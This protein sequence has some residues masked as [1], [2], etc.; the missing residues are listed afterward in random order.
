MAARS[1]SQRLRCAALPK[2]SII[3]A[4]MLWIEMYAAVE[5]QPAAS[6]SKISAASSRDSPAPPTSSRT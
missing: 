2:A 5:V 4:A 3:H 1:G 6:S